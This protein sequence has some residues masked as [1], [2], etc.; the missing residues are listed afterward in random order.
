MLSAA[1]VSQSGATL[2]N[3]SQHSGKFIKNKYSITSRLPIDN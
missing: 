1:A 2:R 3:F